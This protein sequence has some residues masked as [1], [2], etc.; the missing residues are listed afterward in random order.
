MTMDRE[1]VDEAIARLARRQEELQDLRGVRTSG[2]AGRSEELS[3]VARLHDE[4]VAERWRTSR[5]SIRLA[6]KLL[7]R[8][9]RA[10][11]RVFAILISSAD[12]ACVVAAVAILLLFTVPVSREITASVDASVGGV[13][14]R[15]AR[16]GQLRLRPLHITTLSVQGVEFAEY[17]LPSGEIRP[18]SPSQRQSPSLSIKPTGD[19]EGG[20][21]KI[22]RFKFDS[23]SVVRLDWHAGRRELAVAVRDGVVRLRVDPRDPMELRLPQSAEVVVPR[24]GAGQEPV[25]LGVGKEVGIRGN[26]EK[27]MVVTMRLAEFDALWASE[28]PVG[29]DVMF[30]QSTSE[31]DFRRE[32]VE[33]L[34]NSHAHPRERKALHASLIHSGELRL[35]GVEKAVELRTFERLKLL[36]VKGALDRLTLR[37][38]SL[39]ARWRG[40]V[41]EARTGDPDSERNHMQPVLVH[42]FGARAPLVFIALEVWLSIAFVG[43]VTRRQ[44]RQSDLWSVLRTVS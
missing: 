43:L 9:P 29:L 16:G 19:S 26:P 24:S 8:S 2:L 12:V 14:F 3:K 34:G 40:V 44:R 37:P 18:W 28:E 38:E 10:L 17:E 5:P 13:S 32:R 11:I 6:K 1:V 35:G 39:E 21:M 4:L 15:A 41:S 27:E 20:S 31:L 33:T 25:S 7:S 30:S 23:G 36:V 42:Y 22:D